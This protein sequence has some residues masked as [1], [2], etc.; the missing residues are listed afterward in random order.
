M[1]K[2]PLYILTSPELKNYLD[3]Y[4][5]HVTQKKGT[6]CTISDALLILVREWLSTN[7]TPP[8]IILDAGGSCRSRMECPVPLWHDLAKAAAAVAPSS[9]A[10]V[11]VSALIRSLLQE[12][13]DRNDAQIQTLPH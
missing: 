10:A 11:G 6:R 7:R 12:S 2:K 9:G 3:L 5:A 13:K 1:K 8:K 4:R